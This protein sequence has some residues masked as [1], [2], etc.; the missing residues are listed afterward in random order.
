[1]EHDHGAQSHRANPLVNWMIVGLV[2]VAAYFVI[3]E[4]WVHI[5][6][7]FPILI[8]LTCPLMHLFMHHGHG[9]HH[10]RHPDASDSRNPPPTG[11]PEEPRS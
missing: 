11:G 6:P 10:H 8:F 9:H 2:L 7:F 4:H 1:M 3:G 5:A